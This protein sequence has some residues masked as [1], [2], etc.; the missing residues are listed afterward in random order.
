M[1]VFVSCRSKNS[2]MV[3][4]GGCREELGLGLRYQ[5]SVC[6][7]SGTPASVLEVGHGGRQ[8]LFAKHA[9]PDAHEQMSP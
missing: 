6:R 9:V 2:Y 1:C 3:C 7:F 8:E 5:D 4:A